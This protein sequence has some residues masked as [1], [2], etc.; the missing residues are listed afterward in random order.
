MK[1]LRALVFVISWPCLWLG[2]KSN[3]P[4]P[5]PPDLLPPRTAT[6]RLTVTALATISGI[7]NISITVEIMGGKSTVLLASPGAIPPSRT[8][9]IPVLYSGSATITVEAQDSSGKP[10][11]R[12]VGMAQTTFDQSVDLTVTL[13][14]V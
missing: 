5:G 11:A 3:N 6:V 8:F 4:S 7:S 2:C 14:P 10:L 13:Q 12:G 9:D 1:A